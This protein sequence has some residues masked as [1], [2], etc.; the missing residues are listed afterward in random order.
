MHYLGEHGIKAKAI[1]I[2]DRYISKDFLHD[3]ASYYALCFENFSK[4]CKRIHFFDKEITEAELDALLL[5]ENEEMN[6]G[7]WMRH[8]LGFVVVKPIPV[9]VIG[10]TV[11]KTYEE[12]SAVGRRHFWGLRN[13]HVHIFGRKVQLKSLAF[14]EQDGV[15]AACAT[16]AIWTMLNKAATDYHTILKTPA[17]ITSDAAKMSFD[18]SRLFPNKGLDLAQ[19]CQAIFNSGLVSEVKKPDYVLREKNRVISNSYLRRI[20]RAYSPLGIP[21][22]LIIKVPGNSPD[23]SHAITVMGYRMTPLSNKKPRKDIRWLADNIER[24]YVHDD[25]WGPFA[26][27]SF[28]GRFE[29]NTPWTQFHPGQL[30]TSVTNIIVPVYPKVRIAYEDILEIVV[31]LAAILRLLLADSLVAD[32]VWDISINYSEEYKQQIRTEK[33][34]AATKL[35]L[36]K[37]SMPKYVW[38]A[39]AYIGT[40]KIMDFIFDATHVRKG[41]I[42]TEVLCFPEELP[43]ILLDH[44]QRNR[45]GFVKLFTHPAAI[46]YIDFLIHRLSA[47]TQV[48]TTMAN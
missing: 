17:E 38:V 48:N 8:Y 40:E 43:A 37:E 47:I 42:F 7:F 46:E 11:L 34:D 9:T 16:T 5:E 32:L 45:E 30:P 19:I 13:Y 29:L 25:Q 14:Q 3:F 41:M 27:V 4:F 12:G 23:A 33:I 18:G 26:R 24:I 15:L 28:N 2:E 6:A 36:M 1:V 10:Y 20:L 44:I 21:I 35:R 22:I 39:S 31:G